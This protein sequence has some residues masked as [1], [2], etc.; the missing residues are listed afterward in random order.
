VQITATF[1]RSSK[2]Y[3]VYV[4]QNPH[5]G[6]IYI[7]KNDMPT[8]QKSLTLGEAADSTGST[9]VTNPATK[10]GK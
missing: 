9:S 10:P 3:H 7:N 6:K 1:E 4:V 5:V 2:G 8:P